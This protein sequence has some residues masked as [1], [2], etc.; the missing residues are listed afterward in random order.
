VSKTVGLG[1][2]GGTHIFIWYY[3]GLD[4]RV[5]KRQIHYNNVNMISVTPAV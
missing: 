5:S 2:F 3:R 1:I 4:F